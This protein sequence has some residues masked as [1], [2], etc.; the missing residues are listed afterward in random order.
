MLSVAFSFCCYAGLVHAKCS[1]FI[2]MLSVVMQNAILV[3]VVTHLMS[4]DG[5]G[6]GAAC[7]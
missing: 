4:G 5:D 6:G 1:L 7:S 2:V 3:S